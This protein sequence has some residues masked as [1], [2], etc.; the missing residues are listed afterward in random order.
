M[1]LM[2]EIRD[3]KLDKRQQ[4][5]F[6]VGLVQRVLAYRKEMSLEERA[7]VEN[8]LELARKCASGK[9]TVRTLQ[10]AI[11]ELKPF[12][13]GEIGAKGAK[14]KGLEK[15]TR[16]PAEY[17]GSQDEYTAWTNASEYALVVAVQCRK[18][19]GEEARLR[20]ECKEQLKLAMEIKG[21]LDALGRWGAQWKRAVR[22]E[23]EPCRGCL[24][25]A[26]VC[27]GGNEH[28]GIHARAAAQEVRET[29]AGAYCA[30]CFS[31]LKA[32]PVCGVEPTSHAEYPC[33]Q[34]EMIEEGLAC[35]ASGGRTASPTYRGWSIG[36]NG[37]GADNG[38]MEKNRRR[39]W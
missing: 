11:Q 7:V 28:V 10:A 19:R 29:G 39:K 24:A 3:L 31:A 21:R 33:V 23:G 32:C 35:A 1:D 5:L 9:A 36:Y 26:S 37:K 4:R 30:E 16:H 18:E 17:V 13:G 20:G 34:C 2:K 25:Y 14:W 8:V 12:R 15:K 6:A 38:L 22:V 27:K